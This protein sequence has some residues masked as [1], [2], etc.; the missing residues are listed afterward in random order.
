[1]VLLLAWRSQVER[2]LNSVGASKLSAFIFFAVNFLTLVILRPPLSGGRR[3]CPARPEPV[4]GPALFTP[5]SSRGGRRDGPKGACR[6]DL[7]VRLTGEGVR[8]APRRQRSAAGRPPWRTTTRSA[9]F[10]LP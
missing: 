7:S 4:E 9:A 1:M 3:A 10:R 6:R 8:R 2:V 5:S